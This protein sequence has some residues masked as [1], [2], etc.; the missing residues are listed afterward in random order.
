MR[1]GAS[2]LLGI[3]VW[4]A[5]SAIASSTVTSAPLVRTNIRPAAVRLP[6]RPSRTPLR[7]N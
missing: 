3:L 1:E 6:A 2:F 7:S 5:P 4:F